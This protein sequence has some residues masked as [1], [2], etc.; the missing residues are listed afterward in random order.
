[1]LVAGDSLRAPGGPSCKRSLCPTRLVAH[2]LPGSDWPVS[3]QFLSVVLNQLPLRRLGTK[4]E[5][6]A[7]VTALC[8]SVLLTCARR[9]LRDR[10]SDLVVGIGMH[11]WGSRG[12]RF[13]SGRPDAA[14][15]PL[16]TVNTEI[17]GHIC[18]CVLHL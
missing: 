17:S 13:K 6:P 3:R 12:R 14:Q 5:L 7:L 15:S 1:M 10:D 9:D 4:W 16:I 11:G 8:G 18:A 2:G